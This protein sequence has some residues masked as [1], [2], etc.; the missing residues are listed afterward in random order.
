VEPADNLTGVAVASAIILAAMR[1]SPERAPARMQ[2][3]L[4]SAR[5]IAG[6]GAGRLA[7]EEN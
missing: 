1:Q 5:D 2:Q 3:F 4:T 7:L 6:G